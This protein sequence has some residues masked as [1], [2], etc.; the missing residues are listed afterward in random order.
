MSIYIP[1]CGNIPSP[2]CNDCP[3][4][5]LARV[6]HFWLQLV[7][8][9]FIDIT[10]AAEWETA[11]ANGDVIIFPYANGNV[12]QAELLSEG[13]GNV[14]Q[15]VDSYEYTA[16]VHEPNYTDNIPFWNAAKR[17]NQ[18]LFGYCTQTKACLSSVAAMFVPKAPIAADIKSKVD[19]N[20]M[21]KFIQEDLIVPFEYPQAIFETCANT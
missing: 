4:K 10:D 17:S 9:T 21:V 5:E 12:D 13:Y 8:Y 14:P 18:F 3:T 6:R 2:V 1:G 16:N 15:T 7:T 19:V 11:I 20:V